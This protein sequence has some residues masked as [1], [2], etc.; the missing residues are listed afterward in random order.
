MLP[1]D[2]ARHFV[3]ITY[4]INPQQITFTDSADGRKHAF[5]DLLAVVWDRNGKDIGHSADTVDA[6]VSQ[7]E[8]AKVLRTGLQAS[9]EIAVKPGAFRVRLGAVDRVSQQ[10]GTIDVVLAEPQT[11]K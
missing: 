4:L 7:S 6:T 5:V 3:R 2:A 8:Y 11:S 1:P 9:Q 10:V